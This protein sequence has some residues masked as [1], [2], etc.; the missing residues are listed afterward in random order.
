MFLLARR[1]TKVRRVARFVRSIKL[2]IL[3][4][5]HFYCLRDSYRYQSCRNPR[6]YAVRAFFTPETIYIFS[7]EIII[8]VLKISE[9]S[10]ASSS[11]SGK[12]LDTLPAFF[13]WH[14]WSSSRLIP[15]A[16]DN[17]PPS[18]SIFAIASIRAFWFVKWGK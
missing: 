4:N 14:F 18:T 17:L 8:S 2:I 5:L 13:E 7:S 6:F 12:G 1:R 15:W 3:N 10:S 16:T 9:K 11:A